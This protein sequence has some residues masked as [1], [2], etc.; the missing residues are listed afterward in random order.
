VDCRL[1]LGDLDVSS[2][3]RS[4]SITA[5]AGEPTI[6]SVD[7]VVEDCA[8][9]EGMVATLGLTMVTHAELLERLSAKDREEAD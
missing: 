4:V 2:L 9:A 1:I 5:T 8:S 6:V 7:L 3:V